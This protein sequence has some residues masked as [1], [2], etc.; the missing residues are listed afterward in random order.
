[1]PVTRKIT[2]KSKQNSDIKS[3]DF[4]FT[5]NQVRMLDGNLWIKAFRTH[6]LEVYQE[7]SLPTIRDEAWHR[8]DLRY[9]HPEDYQIASVM[10]EAKSVK[11][12]NSISFPS[13]SNSS[14]GNIGIFNQSSQ[15]LLDQNLVEQGVV[16]ADL[17]TA[18]QKYP[19]LIEKI[20]GRVIQPEEGKF[21]SLAAAFAQTGFLLYIPENVILKKPLYSLI[22][23]IGSKTS[24]VTH[25]LIYVGRGSSATCI[26]EYSSKNSNQYS[27]A[28]SG[29]VEMIISPDA[30][31]NFI[32][33]QNWDVQ[34][35]NFTHER[36]RV[37]ANGNLKWFH[38]ALGSKLTKNFSTVDLVGKGASAQVTGLYFPTKTQHVDLDTQQNHIAPQTRSDL[39]Y[40]GALSGKSR[41]VWQGMVYVA[42]G[43]VKSDGYQA[44][45]NLILSPDARAD[46]LPGLEIKA[47]DVK[48]SHG[49]TVGKIDEEQIFY[50][51]SRGIER[52]EAQQLLVEGFF[53][54]I[55]QKIQIEKLQKSLKKVIQEKMKTK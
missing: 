42:P 40:K 10:P 54:P 32:E 33:V 31:L 4:P 25:V 13:R 47:D 53:D 41:S 37:E 5:T 44:N 27:L 8:T 49:A 48:C 45:R 11:F 23:G 26:L 17:Q 39:L 52:K 14:C 2:I 43:A 16:L 35:L 18:E 9:F 36:A 3:R 7:T 19:Q 24:F 50:L 38:A 55:L 30:A 21:A 12:P 6:A 1:M 29:L 15:V 34:T 46:S 20:M 22:S 51:L 28:H